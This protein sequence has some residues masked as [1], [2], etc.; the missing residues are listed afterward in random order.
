MF[1]LS[2]GKDENAVCRDGYPRRK[3]KPVHPPAYCVYAPAVA[4]HPR[5][6]PVIVD[7]A[8]DFLFPVAVYWKAEFIVEIGRL[9][10]VRHY[11]HIMPFARYP[12]VKSQYT[13]IIVYM[14][15]IDPAAP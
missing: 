15:D 9:V 14:K 3:W 5:I 4:D 13:V 7:V 10:Q 12:T 2:P 1:A 11:D 8:I 6:D